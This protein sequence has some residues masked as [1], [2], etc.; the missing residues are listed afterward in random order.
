MIERRLIPYDIQFVTPAHLK[1]DI[2]DPE[3]QEL[4]EKMMNGLPVY[5]RDPNEKFD[6]EPDDEENQGEENENSEENLEPVTS[7][8]AQAE[9]DNFLIYEDDEE[10]KSEESKH[11]LPYENPNLTP[12]RAAL[13][14]KQW[15]FQ[16]AV[17]L[18]QTCERVRQ[19]RI[20]A[21]NKAYIRKCRILGYRP[22]PLP[23]RDQLEQYVITIQR[24]WRGY[25][26]RKFLAEEEIERKIKIG[27]KSC[28]N[29]YEC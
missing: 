7:E 15:F 13:L 22:K 5:V 26:T 21:N 4:F 18:I 1:R 9:S 20:L 27:N 19:A 3:M 28:K 16:E 12:E 29:Y 10:V 6:D 14:K 17:K 24:Y 2:R 8:R 25:S 11:Y 23:P